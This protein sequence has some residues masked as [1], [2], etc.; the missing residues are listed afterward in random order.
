M[1]DFTDPDSVIAGYGFHAKAR[2]ALSVMVKIEKLCYLVRETEIESEDLE[3]DLTELH[4]KIWD[5]IQDKYP[6]RKLSIKQKP[7]VAVTVD[8]FDW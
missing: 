2:D 4:G 3:R 1:V 6:V 8:P 7:T 5:R